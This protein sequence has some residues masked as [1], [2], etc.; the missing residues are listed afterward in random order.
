MKGNL[1]EEQV[2]KYLSKIQCTINPIEKLKMPL[3]IHVTLITCA[4]MFSRRVAEEIVNVV[5]VPVEPLNSLHD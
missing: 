5:K 1:F 2:S 4:Y 3:Y